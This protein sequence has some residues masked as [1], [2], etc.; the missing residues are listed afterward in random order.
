MDNPSIRVGISTCLLENVPQDW[1]GEP[2]EDLLS[3]LQENGLELV[4]VCP[5]RE[6]GVDPGREPV[7]LAG[8]ANGYRVIARGEPEMDLSGAL[9][10][11]GRR[12]GQ[13]QIAM[14]G[15]IFKD[16]GPCCGYDAFPVG[17]RE[18]ADDRI[19]GFFARGFLREQPF[20][21]VTDERELEDPER[22]ASFLDGVRAFERWRRLVVEGGRG[23]RPCSPFTASIP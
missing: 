1:A 5:L 11:R 12:T 3:A 2:R 15:M 18:G 23:W 17:E 10:T 7:S 16:G 21:P 19:P 8:T 22:L 20:L 4:P 9:Q 13:G 14:N 6:V